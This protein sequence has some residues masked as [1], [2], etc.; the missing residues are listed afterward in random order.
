MRPI[1]VITRHSKCAEI[2]LQYNDW[3]R[4]AALAVLLLL[5]KSGSS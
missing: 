5:Y 4:K 2:R 1:M 3:L